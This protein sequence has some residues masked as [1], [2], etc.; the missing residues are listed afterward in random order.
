[1]DLCDWFRA[2]MAT[3]C[4][5]G[6]IPIRVLLKEGFDRHDQVL[7]HPR[8][9]TLYQLGFSCGR[10]LGRAEQELQSRMYVAQVIDCG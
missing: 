7:P 10:G 6:F 1:M 8:A 2:R 3:M 9:S 4:A 5:A